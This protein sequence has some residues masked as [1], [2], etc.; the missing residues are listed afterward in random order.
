MLISISII[1]FSAL[2]SSLPLDDNS[3]ELVK[4]TKAMA[5]KLL[6]MFPL[7]GIAYEAVKFIGGRQNTRLGKALSLPGMML[8]DLTTREPD[9][10]QLEVA[11]CS[12]KA[13]LDLEESLN[14]RD[15]SEKICGPEEIDIDSIDDISGL[16]VELKNYIEG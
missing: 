9:E 6:M 8:Q 14:L 5:F 7:A 16:R 12:I 13:A 11:L 2:F 10:D 3:P 1:F 4:H 15:A